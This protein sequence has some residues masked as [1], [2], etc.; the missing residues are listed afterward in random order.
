MIYSLNLLEAVELLNAVSDFNFADSERRPTISIY[1]KQTEGFVL[2]I[3]AELVSEKYYNH[4]KG[5]VESHKLGL[6]ESE[7]Y[8]IIYGY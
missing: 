6:R 2:C 1:D 4:L 3:K 8:L 5:I 7:V